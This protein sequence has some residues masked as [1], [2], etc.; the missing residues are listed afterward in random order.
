MRLEAAP[1][2]R[3][4]SDC[5]NHKSRTQKSRRRRLRLFEGYC[6][7]LVDS[8]SL[9]TAA[10][11]RCSETQQTKAEQTQ[12]SRLWHSCDTTFA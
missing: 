9:Q 5:G 1:K 6:I 10:T 12:C 3:A 11:T 7:F 2:Y 4:A 8:D